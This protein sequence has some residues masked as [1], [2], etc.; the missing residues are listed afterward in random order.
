MNSTKTPDLNITTQILMVGDESDIINE[1]RALIKDINGKLTAISDPDLIVTTFDEIEPQV[2]LLVC[3]EIEKAERY[4]LDLYRN[5]QKIQTTM[6]STLLVCKAKDVEIAYQLCLRKLF[7]DYV[8]IR[9]LLDPFRLTIS[10]RNLLAEQKTLKQSNELHQHMAGIRSSALAKDQVIQETLARGVNVSS[11]LSQSEKQLSQNI[12]KEIHEL[13]IQMASQAYGDAVQVLDQTALIEKLYQFG[14]EN[15][16]GEISAAFKK[17]RATLDQSLKDSRTNYDTQ[18]EANK[19]LNKWL[20]SILPRI[21]LIDDDLILTKVY[22]RMLSNEGY[23][24]LSCANAME[25]L[26]TAI[27]FTPTLILLDYEMPEMSGID[28]ITR[29]KASPHL[30]KTPI[31]MLTGH[32]ERTIVQQTIKAGAA[33]FLIKSN[34][35]DVILKKLRSHIG[36]AYSATPQLAEG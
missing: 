28:F 23:E 13:A 33:D 4:Y 2:L 8:V 35:K 27:R 9:P 31:I 32:S 25:G 22:T 36:L 26:R 21:L 14:Q 24:V 12:Q 17:P 5:S 34:P 10:I 30:C 11:Q 29:A 1:T 16:N 18:F 19:D 6:H 3:M 15:L 7:D 20:D